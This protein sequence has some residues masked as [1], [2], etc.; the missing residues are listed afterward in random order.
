MAYAA[1]T[2]GALAYLQAQ[3]A[4]WTDLP[5]F[6]GT[7]PPGNGVALLPSAGRLQ[8]DMTGGGVYRMT[9]ALNARH[10]DQQAAIAALDRL[11]YE[12][13]RMPARQS[14]DGWQLTGAITETAPSLIGRDEDGAWLYGS[15]IYIQ[16]FDWRE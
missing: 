4:G 12:I 1:M 3:M 6:I 9:A 10:T 14:G 2:S 13:N 7:M 11:H 16:L 15:T 8:R 5:V